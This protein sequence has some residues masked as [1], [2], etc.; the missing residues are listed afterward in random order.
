M[1]YLILSILT[2]SLLSILMRMSEGRTG[3][4]G[5]MLATNYVVCA[6]LSAAYL[7]PVQPGQALAA[8][9]GLGV[10]NGGFYVLGL[11]L[12]QMNIR[13]NGIVL[14]SVFSRLGSLLVPLALS[15][16]FFGE[17][18]T[19][20]QLIGAVL[21]VGAI[22]GMSGGKTQRLTLLPLVLLFFSDGMAGAMAKIYEEWGSA[23]LKDLFLL[24]TFGAALVTCAVMSLMKRERPDV[25]GVAF[26]AAIGVANFYASRL[27]LEAL[28]RIDAVVVYPTRGV[29]C[30][31]VVTLAGVL[32]FHEKLK[33]RQ[34]AAMGVI[35]AAVALL[36][37]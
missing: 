30:L 25:P 5:W 6:G 16:L 10:V 2:S 8:P 11:V 3:A 22:V 17:K 35:L 33:K 23:G 1:V 4:R 13:R 24:C 29:G 7:G 21:A 15:I 37:L 12:M 28:S 27:L 9:I 34:W 32:L 19:A 36:N 14:P 31:V 20:L 18:P 26:G